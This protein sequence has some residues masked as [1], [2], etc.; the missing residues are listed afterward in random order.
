V[1]ETTVGQADEDA[2]R[3][4]FQ[5]LQHILV[6]PDS[7]LCPRDAAAKRVAVEPILARMDVLWDSPVGDI[8][9]EITQILRRECSAWQAKWAT[10][11]AEE[12]GELWF[13]HGAQCHRLLWDRITLVPVELRLA[14]M[15]ELLDAHEPDWRQYVRRSWCR[16]GRPVLQQIISTRSTLSLAEAFALGKV[17]GMPE[18]EVEPS[19]LW[20]AR[21]GL[22]CHDVRVGFPW[23][24]D[25]PNH[26]RLAWW[27]EARNNRTNRRA[28]Q[29]GVSSPAILRMGMSL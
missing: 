14:A 10:A 7:A 17:L 18:E 9:D 6:T 1:F 13:W 24:A 29:R 8:L 25:D 23:K 19:I 21:R 26:L 27:L 28:I 2:K 12:D 15:I 3:L 4:L 22:I 11:M 20:L 16:Q 5:R